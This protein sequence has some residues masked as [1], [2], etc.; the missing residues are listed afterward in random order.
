MIFASDALAG[1]AGAFTLISGGFFGTFPGR[2]GA[3]GTTP[4][5]PPDAGGLA[6]ADVAAG[7]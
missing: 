6:G 3:L 5:A 1:R 4:F 2:G 7:G